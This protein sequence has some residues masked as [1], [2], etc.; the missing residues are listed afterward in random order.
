[1]RT[2]YK[3][4]KWIAAALVFLLD[5]FALV[6]ECGSFGPIVGWVFFIHS[7]DQ[8]FLKYFFLALMFR[9]EMVCGARARRFLLV[10]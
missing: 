4:F 3:P 2:L 1:M 9:S 7:R 8:I 10:L 5:T 6:R